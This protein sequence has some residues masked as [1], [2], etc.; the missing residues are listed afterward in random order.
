VSTRH[1]IVSRLGWRSLACMYVTNTFRFW[2][3][4]VARLAVSTACMA[5]L[6]VVFVLIVSPP[7]LATNHLLA[8]S[9]DRTGNWDI[10][11]M[12]IYRGAV[13]NLTHSPADE[14]G[15]D[16]S[17]ATHQLAF[18]SDH[19][20]DLLDEIYLMDAYGNDLRP[21]ASG[22]ANYWSPR[23]SPDGSQIVFIMNYGNIRIMNA[24]G[25]GQRNL[26]YGFGP[27]WSPTSNRVSYYANHGDDLN[28]DI[29]LVDSDGRSSY[30]LTLSSAN[31]W[32]P[33]WSPDGQHIAFVSS[34]DGNAEIY[35]ADAACNEN[36]NCGDN[37][38]RLTYSPSTDRSPAWSPDG[39]QIAFESEADGLTQI[40]LVRTDGTDLVPLTTVSSNSRTPIWLDLLDK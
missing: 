37:L 21:V 13:F 15:P 18:Y 27:A 10:Y 30:N 20:A 7:F 19:D 38:R 31:D 39:Q 29:Y 12:D 1:R 4:L 24:D 23:W 35:L 32:D 11:L 16:W 17:A 25:T 2:T 22:R 36:G 9:S 6:A 28:G 14:F 26:V 40:Y 33:A 8:F 3:P 34:R 5:V